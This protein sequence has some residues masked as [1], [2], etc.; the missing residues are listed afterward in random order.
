MRFPYKTLRHRVEALENQCMALSAKLAAAT[1]ALED[2]AEANA[3]ARKAERAFTDG[4]SS[5]LSYAAERKE[6]L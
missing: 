4:V 1:A 3:A 6:R 2:D 5:I